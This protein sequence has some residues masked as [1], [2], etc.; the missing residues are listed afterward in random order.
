MSSVSVDTGRLLNVVSTSI[1]RYDVM[2]TL[3]G[4]RVPK[5]LENQKDLKIK[6]VDENLRYITHRKNTFFDF[7]LFNP[8]NQR[9]LNIHNVGMTSYG[10]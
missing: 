9:C 8:S 10:R 3:F 1:E 6:G 5:R 7:Y 4:R 2:M